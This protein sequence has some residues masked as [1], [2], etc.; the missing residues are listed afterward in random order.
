LVIVFFGSRRKEVKDGKGRK[1][2]W[3]EGRKE[4][5]TE[6]TEGRIDGRNECWM[7]G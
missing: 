4:D 7:E 1:E 6:P 5:G 2:G 3:M